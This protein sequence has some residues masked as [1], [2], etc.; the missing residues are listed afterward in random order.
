M[1]VLM[2]PQELKK[3][4]GRLHGN[5]CAGMK[6]VRNNSK[7]WVCSNKTADELAGRSL[8]T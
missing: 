1:Y 5:A 6:R 7:C 2:N 4:D 3:A 8:Y